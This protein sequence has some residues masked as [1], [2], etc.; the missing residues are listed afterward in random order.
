MTEP[1]PEDDDVEYLDHLIDRV[2]ASD[3]PYDWAK[4]AW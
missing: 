3:P 1:E 2:F 4:E